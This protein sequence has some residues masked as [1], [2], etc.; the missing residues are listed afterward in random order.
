MSDKSKKINF[1]EPRQSGIKLGDLLGFKPSDA[2]APPKPIDTQVPSISNEALKKDKKP[3]GPEIE[4]W[5]SKDGRAG[6]TASLLKGPIPASSFEAI[7]K[8]LKTRLACGGSFKNGE[9]LLQSSEREKMI[10][11]LATLNFRG[12]KCG[13]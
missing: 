9:L 1:E 12:K 8:L 2:P 13:G 7:L 4:I 10:E 5:M 3:T 6:K 11:L